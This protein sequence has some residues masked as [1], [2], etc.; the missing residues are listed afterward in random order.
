LQAK[1]ND[2]FHMHCREYYFGERWYEQAH[3]LVHACLL[4]ALQIEKTPSKGHMTPHHVTRKV[5][6]T[7]LTLI[8][9]YLGH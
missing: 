7:T 1:Q 2:A 9:D 4:V 6:R 5:T 3:L 8:Q